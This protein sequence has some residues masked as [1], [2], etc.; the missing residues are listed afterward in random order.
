LL[1]LEEPVDEAREKGNDLASTLINEKDSRILELEAIGRTRAWRC[2]IQ[3]IN[4]LLLQPDLDQLLQEKM[5]A[6]IQCI[7]LTSASQTWTPLAEDRRAL[8][9][10]QKCLLSD[11][12]QLKLKVS[13]SENRSMILGEMVENLEAQAKELSTSS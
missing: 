4:N 1:H 9:E 11:Y 13:P 12:N 6:E 10:Q 2:A 7:I 5:E 3:S 8:Y